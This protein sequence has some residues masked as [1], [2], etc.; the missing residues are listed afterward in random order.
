MT[1]PTCSRCRQKIPAEDVNIANDIAFCRACNLAHKLSELV[2]GTS[3]DANLDVTRPPQGT[4]YRNRGLGAVIGASHR[5]MGAA[6]GLLFF[7]LFWNGIVSIFVML[8]L[9]ATLH[10][11]GISTPEWFPTPKMNGGEMGIGMT[12]FLW[13]FLT[14]FILIGFAM[15]LAFLSSLAGR[16][17]I[18]I[19]HSAGTVFSGIG[20]VGWR[21]RFNTT[22]IKE[23][24]IESQSWQGRTGNRRGKSQI[25]LEMENGKPIKFGSML[26]PERMQFLAAALRQTIRESTH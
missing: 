15:F 22:S 17:E 8:A 25:V 5:S 7:T 24:R 1:T 14:P 21:R 6:L 23:V 13:L 3:L 26:Q 4:W 12:M 11:L 9:S 10:H 20:L 19:H 16:T 2:H 18:Q